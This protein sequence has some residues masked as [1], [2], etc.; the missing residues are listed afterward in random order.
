MSAMKTFLS[1]F[2]RLRA[3][4]IGATLFF[5][6]PFAATCQDLDTIARV[7]GLGRQ[8]VAAAAEDLQMIPRGFST[9]SKIPLQLSTFPASARTRNISAQASEKSEAKNFRLARG[10]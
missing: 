8:Q 7:Y 3:L 9:I 10:S 2:I 6:F 4:R 5:L 1:T